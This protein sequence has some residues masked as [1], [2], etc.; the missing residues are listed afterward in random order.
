MEANE[1]SI[2]NLTYRI[3]VNNKNN[4]V[5][6]DIT[7][8]DMER[9]QES[10]TK[11]FIYEPIKLDEEWFLKCKSNSIFNNG[12]EYKKTSTGRFEIYVG[13]SLITVIEFVHELQNLNFALLGEDVVFETHS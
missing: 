3:E 8:Y 12:F 6:D 1:L 9:I 13:M 10:Q 7:I 4:T 2:G 11:T 5:I